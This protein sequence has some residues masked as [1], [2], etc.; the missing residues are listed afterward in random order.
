MSQIQN[1]NN[2][3]CG[4][5]IIV[6]LLVN[7]L[8]FLQCEYVSICRSVCKIWLDYLKSNLSRKILNLPPKNI[9]HIKSFNMNFKP[10]NMNRVK[11]YLYIGDWTNLCEIKIKNFEIEQITDK[12]YYNSVTCSNDNYICI[13][14]PL[15]EIF[16]FS[17]DMTLLEILPI[18]YIQGLEI[19]NNDNILVSTY[20]KFYIYN[21]KGKMLNSWDLVDNSNDKNKSY[22]NIGFNRNEIFMIDTFLNQIFVFSYEGKLIRFWGSFGYEFGK[23][24][25]PTEISIY[26]NIVFIIDTKSNKIQAFTSEGKFIFAYEF[27]KD[28]KLKNIIIVDGYVYVNDLKNNA[29]LKYEIIY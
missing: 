10:I 2:N 1:N 15:G 17:S 16:V 13:K 6:E 19:D 25:N 3:L 20:N 5:K 22:R 7:I 4:K 27:Q 24:V 21:P 23:F 28:I 18:R 14:A 11:N 29:I 26:R 8:S 12:K 9:F